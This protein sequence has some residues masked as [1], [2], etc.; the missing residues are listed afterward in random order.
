MVERDKNHPS[1]IFWSLGNES[2]Y[3]PNHDAMAAWIRRRD[4]TRPV[5]Y[6]GAFRGPATDVVSRM[7]AGTDDILSVLNDPDETRP[8]VLCEYAHAMGNST[9]NLQD[10]WDLIE[11]RPQFIGA[12]VWEW[13]D[14]GILRTDDNGREYW[15]YGGDFGEV[16]HD[17][18]FCC[19]GLVWPDRAPHPG[20]WE[21]RKVQQPV[22]VRPV[23]LSSGKIE[24]R[25]KYQFTNLNTLRGSWQ[26]TADGVVIEEGA[27]GALDIPPGEGREVA[28]PFAEP[29]VRSGV[30][31]HLLL[32]FALAEDAPWA[33]KGHVLATEQF[34]LPC[35]APAP[36]AAE[37][38]DWPPLQL[39][40]GA[41]EV[42]ITGD[43]LAVVFSKST[44][45]MTS[46]KAAGAELLADDVRPN[47]WRAP[48]DNDS[49]GRA[50]SYAD[51]WREA[52]LDRLMCEVK[53]VEAAMA[54]PNVVRVTVHSRLAPDGN[55]AG[56]DCETVFTVYGSGDIVI[57]SGVRADSALPVLPRV[58]LRMA[59]PRGYETLT[60]L[61]RGP[62]E[63]HWD[64]KTG[65]HVGR[66]ESAVDELHTPYIF[67]SENGTRAD[68]RWA[69]LTDGGGRGLLV[70]GMPLVYVNAQHHTIE[71]LGKA[72]HTNELERRDEITLCID[73]L[74]MGVGGDDSWSARTHP[75]YLIQPG[76][77]RYS[78]RLRPLL[79]RGDDP[80][81][82]ARA[83][84]PASDS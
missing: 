80:A 55:A 65:A 66:Y 40:D 53:T 35:G 23:D 32:T 16:R 51:S 45:L 81:T 33:P 83:L 59:L 46:L 5:H 24:I 56:I 48:T 3:G 70:V 15:A 50:N 4:P 79:G 75:E 60:W 44:G 69:A 41:D 27:L 58:G 30:E 62:H 47:F 64:R 12:F 84:P 18:N 71:D 13:C 10:Y 37:A 39:D 8:Y 57:D 78:I 20:M 76:D 73:H 43:G 38:S 82:L 34:E 21:C 49:G 22:G 9:G 36:A 17:G 1:I 14:H 52:G 68:V 61:G 19:D 67:P 28:I 26:V 7:Y 42:R 11:E 29:E 77:F 63:C 54:S 25:N 31:Y 72:T 2:G 6:E 74:H